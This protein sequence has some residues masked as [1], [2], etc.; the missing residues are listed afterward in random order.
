VRV[1]AWR[2]VQGRVLDLQL[3]EQHLRKQRELSRLSFCL[4]VCVLSLSLSFYVSGVFPSP[5]RPLTWAY[6]NPRT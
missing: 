5:V 3:A 2:E 1:A 4:S 6:K